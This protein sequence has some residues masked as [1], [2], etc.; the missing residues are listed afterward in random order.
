MALP[1][2]YKQVAMATANVVT[3]TNRELFTFYVIIVY[4]RLLM[5]MVYENVVCFLQRGFELPEAV[6]VALDLV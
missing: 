5:G 6:A 1:A 2:N 4:M 3:P